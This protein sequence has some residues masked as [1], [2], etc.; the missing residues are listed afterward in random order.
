MPSLVDAWRPPEDPTL[1][2]C[3]LGKSGLGVRVSK[4]ISKSATSSPTTIS[5]DGVPIPEVAAVALSGEMIVAV[6]YTLV[7]PVAP[8]PF[9]ILS[10]FTGVLQSYI[11]VVLT[12]SYISLAVK[13]S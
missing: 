2:T 8:L 9:I 12:M 11:F 3:I 4:S 13:D 6:I 7:Q 1:T 10:M 5:R